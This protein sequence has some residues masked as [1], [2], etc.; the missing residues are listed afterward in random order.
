MSSKSFLQI[1]QVEGLDHEVKTSRRGEYWRL[2]L[3]GK[4]YKVKAVFEKQETD[5]SSVSVPANPE[6]CVRVDFD[7]K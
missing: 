1:I 7:L 6:K 2:V 5:F 3:A 4:D